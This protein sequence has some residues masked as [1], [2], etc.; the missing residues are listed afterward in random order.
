MIKFIE[1]NK[2][3][4]FDIGLDKDFLNRTQKAQTIKG[5]MKL[6]YTFNQY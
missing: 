6:M 5:K 1:E 2:E 3:Y 4:L